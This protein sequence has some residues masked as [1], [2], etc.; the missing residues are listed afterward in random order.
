MK[1]MQ[2]N[3]FLEDF[4]KH[5]IVTFD[6]FRH[7]YFR[8]DVAKIKKK[9]LNYEDFSKELRSVVMYYFWSKSEYEVVITSWPPYIDREELDRLTSEE[10]YLRHNVR[11]TVGKKIDVYQQLFLN[12]E[13]FVGYV[14]ES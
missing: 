6:I 5:E 7:S 4:N 14:Y 3:V 9:K 12:W 8:K 2:W 1:N 10:K 11:L 13:R